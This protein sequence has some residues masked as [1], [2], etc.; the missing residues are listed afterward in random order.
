MWEGTQ[1]MYE[2]SHLGPVAWIFHGQWEGLSIVT[3]RT[4]QGWENVGHLERHGK[5]T[6]WEV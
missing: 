2:L 5:M 6:E 1:T 4:T 3:T